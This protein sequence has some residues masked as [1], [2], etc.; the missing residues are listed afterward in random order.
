MTDFRIAD[1]GSL[2]IL[3][4]QTSA[5]KAWADEHFPEDA[6]NWCSGTVIERRFFE[7]IYRGILEDGLSIC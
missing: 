5:A 4:P 7:D 3:E 2:V 6:Q 1:H